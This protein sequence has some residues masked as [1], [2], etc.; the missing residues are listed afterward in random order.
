MPL[1]TKPKCK[2]EMKL[3][4]LW[5]AKSARDQSI[6]Y[7]LVYDKQGN[8]LETPYEV[9]ITEANPVDSF[10][11]KHKDLVYLGRGYF[12]RNTGFEL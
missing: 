2:V 6:Y 3:F 5:H 10:V 11:C 7:K 4:H 12:L 9:I 1:Q 8:K